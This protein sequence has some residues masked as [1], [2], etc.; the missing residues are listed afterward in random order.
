MGFGGVH[1]RQILSFFSEL[2]CKSIEASFITSNQGIFEELKRE[3]TNS[4]ETVVL[5]QYF[6]I[7]LFIPIK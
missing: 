4:T 5:D 6:L 3:N 2:D 1:T 7:T